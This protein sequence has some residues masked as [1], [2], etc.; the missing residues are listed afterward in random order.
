MKNL[1][2]NFP[3]V[4]DAFF[5]ITNKIQKGSSY[6]E[7]QNEL[8][9]I[10]IFASHGY[11][12]GLKTHIIRALNLGADKDEVYSSIVLGLPVVG[13]VNINSSLDIAKE[14]IIELEKS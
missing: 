7:K 1:I 5:T 13:I 10:G 3:E 9:L 14:I 12:R 6:T 11:E 8:I 4:A 2:N